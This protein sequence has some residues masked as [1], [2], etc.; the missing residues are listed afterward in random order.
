MIRPTILLCVLLDA[1][2][3]LSRWSFSVTFPSSSMRLGRILS[4][5]SLVD[6]VAYFV[7]LKSNGLFLTDPTGYLAL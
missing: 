4:R 2:S 7:S 5:A 1:H 3:L 6:Y